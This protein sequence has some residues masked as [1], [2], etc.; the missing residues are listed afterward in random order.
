MCVLFQT[1]YIKTSDWIYH[2]EPAEK[3]L[4]NHDNSILHRINKNPLTTTST[5]DVNAEDY[6]PCGY[7]GKITS[8][9]K[10]GY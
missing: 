9:M 7:Q 6:Q 4:D 2:I 8:K 10:R 5:N 1:G 3:Y